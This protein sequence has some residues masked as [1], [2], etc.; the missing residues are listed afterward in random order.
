MQFVLCHW[1]NTRK[2]IQLQQTNYLFWL[3]FW[4]FFWARG[5]EKPMERRRNHSLPR[6]QPTAHRCSCVQGFRKKFPL[7]FCWRL[8]F[9][10]SQCCVSDSS[11]A[12]LSCLA[13]L[14]QSTVSTRPGWG[15]PAEVD[16]SV[17]E[18]IKLLNLLS[19]FSVPSLSQAGTSFVPSHNNVMVRKTA[20]CLSH[21]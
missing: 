3:F 9:N 20:L 2:L 8:A 4:V 11:A 10:T 13:L 19:V 5:R 18:R 14:C 15:D 7:Y 12:S 21:K 17:I 1:E 6:E 16:T